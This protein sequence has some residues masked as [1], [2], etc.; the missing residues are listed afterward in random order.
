MS[1]LTIEI[2]QKQEQK[3]WEE[4]Y[5]K[6]LQTKTIIINDSAAMTYNCS[7]W[8]PLQFNT[9]L[10]T[11]IKH[12][13]SI[14]LSEKFISFFCLLLYVYIFI[15]LPQS[16]VYNIFFYILHFLCPLSLS[17]SSCLSE[18]WQVVDDKNVE[19]KNKKKLNNWVLVYEYLL[20][21]LW[22]FNFLREQYSSIV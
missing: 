15:V 13:F 14:W 4:K 12:K 9:N 16:V 8:H 20:L 6:F 18:L 3:F 1:S 2:P 7:V 10:N 5:L 21:L 11:K 22:G 19:I 17:S